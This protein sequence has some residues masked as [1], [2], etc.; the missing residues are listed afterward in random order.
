M[1]V[2]S[3][4][5]WQTTDDSDGAIARYYDYLSGIRSRLPADIQKLAGAGGD[6]TLNDGTIT[7]LEVSLPDARVDIHMDG[8]WIADTVVGLR[9]LHLAYS[10]VTQ[11][12]STIDP[13]PNGP[14]ELG[15]SGYGDHGADEFELIG[16]DL[17]EH[18][19]LFWSGIILSIRFSGFTLAYEDMP[20]EP[21]A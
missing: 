5:K 13:E 14:D 12:D 21:A 20:N 16:D 9:K 6:I 4:A 15:Y 7:R 2:F 11:F 1:K 17:Y 8:K 10:G 19:M 3:L 18:R